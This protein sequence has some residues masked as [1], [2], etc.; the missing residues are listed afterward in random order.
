MKDKEKAA[1]LLAELEDIFKAAMGAHI[2]ID[3]TTEKSKLPEWDSLNHLKL[4]VELENKYNLD[5]S[6][7]EIENLKTVKGILERL[8]A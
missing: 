4:V 3:I 5:L 7:D 8:D 2:V 1:R 6:M